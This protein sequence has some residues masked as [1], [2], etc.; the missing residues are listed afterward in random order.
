MVENGLL[1]KECES[2]RIGRREKIDSKAQF[3]KIMRPTLYKNGKVFSLLRCRLQQIGLIL[4]TR[5]NATPFKFYVFLHSLVQNRR[6][7]QS[8]P[9]GLNAKLRSHKKG[10]QRNSNCVVEMRTNP[11]KF[12]AE[13]DCVPSGT[14]PK[15][16]WQLWIRLQN[17]RRQEH[18]EGSF[19]VGVLLAS[20]LNQLLA[21]T[22]QP[23]DRSRN[24]NLCAATHRDNTFIITIVEARVESR[25]RAT[26]ASQLVVLYVLYEAI[27]S[28]VFDSYDSY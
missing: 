12:Y 3:S 20:F 28:L 26:L 5:V 13:N 16:H 19:S 21:R 7:R 2:E 9:T 23:G 25:V 22:V 17:V 4:T 11:T 1:N 10:I 15:E 18:S 14:E 6:C 27:H 24:T 8:I